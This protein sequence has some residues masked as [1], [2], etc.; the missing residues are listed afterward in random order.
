MAGHMPSSATQLFARFATELDWE[1]VPTE[2]REAVRLHALDVFGCGLAAVGTEAAPFART[3]GAEAAPGSSS[4]LGLT[5]PV[6]ASAAALVNGITCHALDYDDTHPGSIAHVSAVVAPAALAA[7]EA[8]GADG[9]QLALALLLGDEI[10]C[11]IGRPAGDAFHLRGFH[12]TAVCGVFGA[13]LAIGSLRGLDAATLVHALGIAGSMASGLMAYLSDGAETKRLH[14]GWMAH[15]A[16]MAV[17]FAAHGATGPAPV[18][19]GLNGVYPAFIDRH[20]VEPGE[21]ADDLGERWDT[22]EIAFKPYPACHFVHAPLDAL[23]ALSGERGFDADDVEAI[24]V[25]SPRAGVE[26]VCDPSE[27]KRRPATPYESKFSAPFALAAWLHTG[28]VDPT[29]FGEPLL[30]DPSVLAIA[31]RIDFEERQ[32]ESFPASLPGGVRVRLR[33]GEV[34]EHH[35]R[36]QRGGAHNPMTAADVCAKFRQNARTALPADAAERLEHALLALDE[37]GDLAAF[38]ALRS[39]GATR[40]A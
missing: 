30:S 22:L 16:Q 2:V 8:V 21:L 25:F 23:V 38:A 29:T 24:T 13:T 33:G 39:A 17:T 18:L 7:A 12:P 20:D 32:Y 37:Q 40:S 34:L 31:E 1:T 26:L 14:P 15:A 36:H 10:T 4:A 3:I 6:S 5:S 28:Q 11:R 19:E 9:R 35:L 27:R